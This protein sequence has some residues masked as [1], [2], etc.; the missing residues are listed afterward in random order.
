M[1]FN[2]VAVLSIKAND[3]RIHF[4]YISNDDAITIKK[5]FEY[6]KNIVELKNQNKKNLTFFLAWYKN[7]SKSF[8]FW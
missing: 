7:E 4:W 5:D 6:Q 3:C 8:D 2:D 1:N